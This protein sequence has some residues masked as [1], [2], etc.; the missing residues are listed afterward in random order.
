MTCLSVGCNDTIFNGGACVINWQ[1]YGG[2]YD[3]CTGTQS[4]VSGLGCVIN[5]ANAGPGWRSRC[6]GKNPYIVNGP[7]SN[8]SQCLNFTLCVD[9]SQA[10][11][12]QTPKSSAFCQSC[13]GTSVAAFSWSQGVWRPNPPT[14]I[15]LS[16]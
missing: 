8:E 11:A 16:W 1:G 13:G 2:S 15:P 3:F 12:I 14:W 6:T 4:G 7:S 5:T 9:D 10:F